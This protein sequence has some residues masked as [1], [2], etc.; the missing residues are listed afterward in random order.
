M[1]SIIISIRDIQ[2]GFG[3]LPPITA[4]MSANYNVNIEDAY[5]IVVM[6]QQ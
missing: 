2:I 4:E 3:H 1:S 6:A 5:R